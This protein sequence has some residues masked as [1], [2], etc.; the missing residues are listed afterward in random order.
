MGC[1][2]CNESKGEKEIAKFLDK[3]KIVYDRQKKFAGCRNIFELPFD[4]YIPSMRTCIEF[5]G[6]QHFEP[7]EFFGGIPAYETLK[8][9][10]NIKTE[11][12]EDNYIN[13]IRIRYDQEN[14]IWEILWDNLKSLIN[15]KEVKSKEFR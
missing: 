8:I 12:C 1:S 11:Y 2:N 13:L 7:M 14:I 4:F 15:N 3:Y 9:N 5:D 10:D 6:K